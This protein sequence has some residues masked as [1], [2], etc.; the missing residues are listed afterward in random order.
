MLPVKKKHIKQVT[1]IE[2]KR[3]GHLLPG[4]A[5]VKGSQDRPFPAD[6]ETGIPAAEGDTEQCIVG[7]PSLMLP[8]LATIGSFKDGLETAA[9]KTGVTVDQAY[10]LKIGVG[11]QRIF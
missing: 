3:L 1:W 9:N 11:W 10:A 4:F 2:W 7:C 8:G 6:R 5:T